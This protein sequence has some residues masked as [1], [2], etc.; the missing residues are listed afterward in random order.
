MFRRTYPEVSCAL[1]RDNIKRKTK[2]SGRYT[3]TTQYQSGVSIPI[4]AP[5]NEFREIT[6]S[7]AELLL[8]LGA[9]VSTLY[10][11]P[12]L[13]EGCCRSA[14]EPIWL[15]VEEESQASQDSIK[16]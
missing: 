6:Y 10:L 7:R 15:V 2:V 5:L 8:H 4:R 1:L 9:M 13:P 3:P 12:E 16:R 14:E 11:R